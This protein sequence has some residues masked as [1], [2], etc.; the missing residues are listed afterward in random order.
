VEKVP[1]LSS[2]FWQYV[3]EGLLGASF[4]RASSA[5]E[6]AV[7]SRNAF[8]HSLIEMRNRSRQGLRRE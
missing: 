8:D 2:L 4:A 6:G 7:R 5:T 1:S 3:C